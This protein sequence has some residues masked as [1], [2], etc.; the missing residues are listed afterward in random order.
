V[1]FEIVINWKTDRRVH[2]AIGLAVVFVAAKWLFTSSLFYAAVDMTAKPAEGQTSAGLTLSALLPIVFDLAVGALIF[3]GGYAINLF[4]LLFGRVRQLVDPDTSQ[5]QAVSGVAGVTA[6]ES[7]VSL[8]S[9]NSMKRAVDSLGD[10]AAM[11]DLDQMEKLRKQIRKPY[12]LAA[13]NDAYSKG[14]TEAAATLVDE[15]NRMH[16]SQPVRGKKGNGA[17]N[18]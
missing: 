7:A 14:D 5:P 10:A 17:T 15:L 9:P 18:G 4:D 2:L 1:E 11:N 12:A 8:D 13:L 16:D 6:S 3:I